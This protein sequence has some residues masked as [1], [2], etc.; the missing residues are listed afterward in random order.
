MTERTDSELAL[1]RDLLELSGEGLALLADEEGHWTVIYANRAFR[2]L[3]GLE[4]QARK[5]PVRELLGAYTD[6]HAFMAALRERRF[7]SGPFRLDEEGKDLHGVVDLT[8]WEGH[9]LKAWLL[10]IQDTTSLVALENQLDTAQAEIEALDPDDRLTGLKNGRFFEAALRREWA[11]AAR[12][13]RRLVLSLFDLDFFT[14]YNETF[15]EQAGD[16]CL[17][18]VGRA[19]GG[20]FRR[21]GDHCARI[22]GQRFAGLMSAA[23][24]HGAETL[25]ERAAERVRALCIH[26]PRAPRGKY[27]T[28]SVA[29]VTV[30]PGRAPRWDDLM[31]FAEDVLGEA[32][33]GGRDTVLLRKFPGDSDGA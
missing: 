29:V 11:I 16:A 22:E 27:L 31:Q 13:E 30:R 15:G 25:G 28:V 2:R 23:E 3:L 26:N 7:F 32:K 5:A 17:K 21:A 1:E 33:N 9:G 6:D 12:E 19:I 4:E 18:M 20:C 10:R 8:P 14:A 24:S